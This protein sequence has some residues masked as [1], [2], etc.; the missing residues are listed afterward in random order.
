VQQITFGVMYQKLRAHLILINTSFKINLRFL[1]RL[2]IDVPEVAAIPLLGI[3]PKDAL[4]CHQGTCSTMSIAAL[5]MKAI[6]WKQPRCPTTEKWI[7]KM[8]FIYTV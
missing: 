8:W 3:Y 2:D 4:P 7:Q 1:R 5:F 6:S